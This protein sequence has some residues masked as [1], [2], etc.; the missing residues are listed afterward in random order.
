MFGTVARITTKPGM[1]SKLQDLMKEYE[2][3]DIPGFIST[4]IYRTDE[5]PNE[6]FLTVVWKDRDSYFA[7]ANSPEQDARYRKMLDYLAGEPE[8]HDGEV[9]Y[10]QTGARS[11]TY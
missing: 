3:L 11:R 2:S 5:N 9:I 7:N 10:S 6:Y 1:E 4:Y 8:W